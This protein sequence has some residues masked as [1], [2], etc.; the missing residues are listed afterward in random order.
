MFFPPIELASR[1]HVRTIEQYR[2]MYHRSIHER[3]Q[4]W[5]EIAG[6]LYF[7]NLDSSASTH[8]FDPSRGPVHVKWFEGARTNMAYNCLEK[9]IEN[10]MG[11]KRAL[12]FEANDEINCTEFTFRELLVEVETF[13][14]FLIAHGVQKGDRVVMYL[15]MIPALPIAMLACSRIGAV[16]SVVFAGYSAKS[17][18]QR[19]HDC[20]AKMVITASASRRAEKIIPLKKIVDEAMEI[21]K[22]DGFCVNK[23]VVKHNADIE[24]E[25][26]PHVEDVPFHSDRDLW[27][28][29]SVAE[30]RTDGKPAPI[31]FLDSC[32][33][34]FILYTSGSTG[35]P[36]GVV[37]SV[38]GYQ[39][40]VYATSKFVF[41][42]HAGED[43]LFCT[44]DLGWITG[45]SYGLY[46]PLLNGCAT[47]LFEGVPTYPDAGVWW[48]TVDKYD[49]TVFYTSP[50]A[51]R[52]LQGYGEDPVKRSS[53]ASL[54]ILGTVGAPI[55][56]ETWLWYHS[57][58]GDDKLPICDT[59]WQTETG[60]HII[61]PLPG[62]TPLK[63]SSATFPFFGIVPVLLDPKD[64]TEIQGEGEGCLCIKEP[65]PGM[66]LD[67]HGAHERYENSYFKVYEGG[68]YFS[69]D[70]A[71]RDSD[72]YLFITG[73]LDDVMNVSGHRI[74]TAEVESALVQH[75]SCIEAAVV[76]IAHEVK[77]ESIVAYVILDPSR[78]I[79]KR[80]SLEIHQRE[81]ITNVRMEIGP[82]AA[83]ERVVI[84]KDLPKTRSGKIMRRI[85]K[86]IAAGDVDD[87]GDVSALADPGVVD[88]IIKAERHARGTR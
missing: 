26:V 18:A 51:L 52:T 7:E 25:G 58:V 17:L 65:W 75:S 30:F 62:A 61:T 10:G 71:R 44:A 2:S 35:K 41:D 4:F 74:G 47:V 36:K 24:I 15:P 31:E 55:S 76:S 13:A 14:K 86:K 20:K 40:Y 21:C 22:S 77:G 70:G 85:L 42:L 43:V 11:D 48:Q 83:P 53:R 23:V 68:Y 34:A 59:W 88:E 72:G 1:A 82:F 46:G 80:S 57:V 29:E 19:V 54:R 38:G 81:L 84:V 12:I 64:G 78:S 79:E 27:W 87:F 5:T 32:D 67:V 45:H 50:T 69:G 9:Q 56:S 33:T 60:G 16:H 8:N 63:A 37:H 73:R 49:V 39:T 3:D 6:E 28:N 66:F